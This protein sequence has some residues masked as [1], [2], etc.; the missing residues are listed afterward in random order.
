MI[1]ILSQM[2]YTNPKHNSNHKCFSHAMRSPGGQDVA[3][4]T[5]VSKVPQLVEVS[6]VP[7]ML[8]VSQ[9]SQ[10][11]QVPQ[12]PKVSQVPWV[13]EVAQVLQC[14]LGAQGA[15]GSLYR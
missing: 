2:R 5:R 8:Q 14:A 9:V 4:V 10:V 15:Q 6:Q 1:V 13:W 11:L 3:Q 7:R 12:V